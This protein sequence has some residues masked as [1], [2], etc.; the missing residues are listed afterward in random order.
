MKNGIKNLYL[1]ITAMI[2]GFAFVAQSFAMD[3]I[4]PF[5]FLFSRT[6]LGCLF[7]IVLGI[8][9][10]QFK[11]VNYK[12]LLKD[13]AMCGIVLYIAS[14]LQQIGLIYT[15]ASRGGFITVMYIVIVPIISMFIGKK[16]SLKNW[17]C[18]LLSLFGLYLLCMKGE[19]GL[20]LGDLCIL[21]SA[22]MFSVHIMVIDKVS[23]KYSALVLSCAQ[24]FVMCLIGVL[25]AL[26]IDGMPLGPMK[27]ASISILYAGIMS[28]GIAYTL[29]TA[30]QKD[31]NPTIASLIMSLESVFAAIG[32][33][34]ILHESMS[35]REIIGS[36]LIFAAIII[37][38]IEPKKRPEVS[39]L[40]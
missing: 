40:K 15:P 8:F 10:K 20:E 11:G 30:G 2:W 18:V 37:I 24:Y 23:V 39:D 35:P 3:S 26:F 1:L 7:L 4:G 28:T 19:F 32:G 29:Q 17:F 16:V 22:F 6:I 13:G 9:T 5:A 14:I 21:L 25:P 38:Q 12:E 34:L 33:F 36:C 27:E 31:N